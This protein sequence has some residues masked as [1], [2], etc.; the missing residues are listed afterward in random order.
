MLLITLVLTYLLTEILSL[1]YLLSYALVLIAATLGNFFLGSKFV[2]RTQRMHKR[3]FF[4][5]LLGLVIF[6]L[7]DIFITRTFTDVLHLHY[8][9]S[10]TLA[11]VLVFFTKYLVYDKILFR[12]TSFLYMSKHD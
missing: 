2:F 4:F 1:Y 7:T 6:Y 8:T 5:Y 12:D 3:R 10:I 9:L 11:R